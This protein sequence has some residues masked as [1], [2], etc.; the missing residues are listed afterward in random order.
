MQKIINLGNKKASLELLKH[1]SKNK[2]EAI[3]I[4]IKNT[5]I[6]ELNKLIGKNVFKND[7]VYA[8]ASMFWEIM[9]PLGGRGKHNFHNLSPENV[10]D[11]LS[12]IRNSTQVTLSYDNRYVI[13]TLATLECSVNIIAVVT[14]TGTLRTNVSKKITKIITLYPHK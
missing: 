12:T 9:Q 10:Y 14:P 4:R 13:V 2:Y 7:M 6:K 3:E 11:A 8:D 1:L 5:H